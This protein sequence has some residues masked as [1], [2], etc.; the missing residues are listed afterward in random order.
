MEAKPLAAPAIKTILFLPVFLLFLAAELPARHRTS[1]KVNPPSI[2]SEPA[3]QTITAGQTAKF[4][5]TAT[6]T[7]PLTYQ[8]QKNGAAISG[9]NSSSYTTPAETASAS[10]SQF[11]V[12]V[13]NSAG[14][15]LSAAATL[16]VNPVPGTLTPSATSLNFGSVN[17]G[18]N[19]ALN[20]TFTNSGSSSVTISKVTISGPGFTASGISAGLVIAPGQN[21]AMSVVFAPAASGAVTGSV[22]VASNASN[23]PVSVSLSATALQPSHSVTL[24][25]TEGTSGVTVIGYNVYRGTVSGGPYVKL[26]SSLVSAESYNDAGVQSGHTYYYVVTASIRRMWRAHTQGRFRPPFQR[27][28]AARLGR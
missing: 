4:S 21:A 13:G 3:S 14:S 15:V 24:D 20:V 5:V 6:G 16:T 23:S 18:A 28:D 22:S 8:W 27:P 25:W 19:S 26:D 17:V 12:L 9:A 1:A 7:A 2:T 10:G 11:S